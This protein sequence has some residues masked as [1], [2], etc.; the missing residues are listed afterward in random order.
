MAR[1]V[2]VLGVKRIVAA[3]LI[4]LGLLLPT[5]AQADFWVPPVAG[6][7]IRDFDPAEPDWESG[8]R[9]VDF[10]AAPGDPVV[11]PAAGVVVFAGRVAG[12]PVVTI[13]HGDLRSTLQPVEAKL[14]PG[15][16]VA[17]GAVVGRAAAGGHCS[18]CVHWGVKQGEA[19][20][21]PTGFVR[22]RHPQLL[23][24]GSAKRLL[25]GVPVDPSFAR[26]A[27]PVAGPVTSPFG[28]RKHPITGVWKL[29]DGTDFGA[30]CGTPIRPIAPGVVKSVS[31]HKAYGMRVFIDH[32]VID[33]HKYVSSYNHLSRFGTLPGQMLQ[34]NSSL[35]NVGTTGYSTGCHLHLMIWRDGNLINP[36]TVL[37]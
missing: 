1:C 11:S 6:A 33:G 34:Q 23:P 10:T 18:G 8:H 32:G 4:C 29:H 7:K 9:G 3:T 36:E 37:G 21:D 5:P 30:S 13:R 12:V 16:T 22:S 26:F 17:A 15:E 28:R 27:R 20:L 14:S 24:S 25:P 31:R 19:Y 2:T 35:G